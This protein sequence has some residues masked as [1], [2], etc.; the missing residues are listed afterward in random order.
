MKILI[1]HNANQQHAGDDVVV[2]HESTLLESAGHEVVFFR[3]SNWDVESYTGIRRINL[4]KNTVWAS[5]TKRDFARLLQEEKPDVVHVHNTFVMISPSIYSACCE[6]RVP[7]VQTLHNYRLLCP[8]ATLFR[9]GKVCEE[10]MQHSLLRSVEYGCY[11]DSRSATAVTA[12]MLGVHRLRRT[13]DREVSCFVALSE[14]SRSKFIEGGLPADKIA[15]KPNFV[16]PDP[17]NRTGDGEYAIFVG[18]LSPEKRVEMI[19]QAWKHLGTK[20]PVLIVG[21]G[22]EEERL[23]KQAAEEGIA[24]VTF[25]G[26]LPREQTIAALNDARFLI[27]PSEWYEGFPMTLA[28][29][30]ACGTPVICA[31][32]GTMQEV[33][34]DGRTGLHYKPGDAEDLARKVEWAWTHPAEVRAMGSEARKDYKLKYTAEQNYPMLMEIYQRAREGQCRAA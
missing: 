19:L 16:D 8:A 24:N 10:C 6:A 7:V 20:I 30:F 23:R 11:R 14:F 2:E 25:A 28:E 4:A 21:G 15:V 12:L 1:A 32:M 13:W 26:K 31:R 3:R 5:D 17:G 33:V 27:F 34:T 9:E 22:P 29:S 18:R